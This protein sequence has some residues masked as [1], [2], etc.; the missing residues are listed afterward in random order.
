[1][2]TES[3]LNHVIT[4]YYSYGLLMANTEYSCLSVCL[5]SCVSI[6]LSVLCLS[7]CEHNNSKNKQWQA[8]GNLN[9]LWYLK[10][11]QTSFNIN[12]CQIKVKVRV[13][14]FLYLPQYKLLKFF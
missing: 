11:A 8:T 4:A 3:S 2:H 5:S 6:H 14:M 13:E 10:I 9:M 1:M 12:H 7:V